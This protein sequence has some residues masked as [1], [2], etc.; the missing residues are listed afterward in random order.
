VTAIAIGVLLMKNITP[1]PDIF[2]FAKNADMAALVYGIYVTFIVAN[3]MLIPIGLLAIRSSSLLVSI[4]RQVLLP[5]IVVFC[6][7]GSY[8]MNGNYFDVTVM[9]AM[10]LLG[11]VLE[12]MRVPLG[13]VV[14]GIILGGQ[15]EHRFIQCIQTSSSLGA[16]FSSPISIGLSLTSV[17]LWVTP[18]VISLMRW[19]QDTAESEMK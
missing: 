15:I 4:P 13:P 9:I 19:P 7:V 14:L 2:D 18:A 12:S 10:G 5:L 3:L 1:G 17:A 11:F 8:A 6:V 16:F